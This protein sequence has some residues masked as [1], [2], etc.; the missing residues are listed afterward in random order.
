M[1]AKLGNKN[2]DLLGKML[3][4]HGARHRVTA[5]NIANVNTPNYRRREFRFDTS[6]RQAMANGTSAD[7]KS[8]VGHV[9]RPNTTPVRNNGNNVAIDQE[10]LQ[11]G[12]NSTSYGI[13]GQLYTRKAQAMKSAVRGGR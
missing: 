8:V 13:Y 2:M 12:T 11:L 3:S 9:S 7:Y 5:Q 4:L 6:L 10:M 1:I